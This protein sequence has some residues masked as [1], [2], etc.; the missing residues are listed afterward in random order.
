MKPTDVKFVVLT[1]EYVTSAIRSNYSEQPALVL[2]V[3]ERTI[4]PETNPELLAA[5]LRGHFPGTHSPE[6][7][8]GNQKNAGPILAM[9]TI[10]DS[11][12]VETILQELINTYGGE[13]GPIIT[14]DERTFPNPDQPYGIIRFP[15]SEKQRILNQYFGL[16]K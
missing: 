3:Y 1:A 12:N 2:G 16:E 4:L 8:I 6:R 15:Y 10:R 9:K 14:R 5:R 13:E 11:R 7:E